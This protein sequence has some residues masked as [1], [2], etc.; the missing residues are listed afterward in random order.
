MPAQFLA[1]ADNIPATP[2]L[3]GLQATAIEA[4]SPLRWQQG[5]TVPPP[6]NCVE[7]SGWD[8]DVCAWPIVDGDPVKPV[9]SDSADSGPSHNV[10]PFVLESPFECASQNFKVVDFAGR[11]RRQLEAA[12]TKGMEHEFWTGTLKPANPNLATGATVIGGG[13]YSPRHAFAMLGQALSNCAHGGRGM[14]HAPT[15][16]VD[17]W[18]TQFGS[19]IEASGGRLVTVNRGDYIVSGT[20]YNGTGPAGVSVSSGQSWAYATGPV[21]YWLDDILVFPDTLGEA[22]DRKNNRVEYRAER[23]AMVDFDACCHFAILI[24]SSIGAWS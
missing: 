5:L 13:A 17:D 8:P 10:V 22:L 14:L 18:L 15:F 2:P 24:D 7:A 6:E 3:H 19:G 16:I 23:F 9:K 1:L 4:R 11:A 21:R 12:T 20:G